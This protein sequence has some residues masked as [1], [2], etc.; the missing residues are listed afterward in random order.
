MNFDLI[1]F[2]A[3]NNLAG[4]NI[5]LDY[6]GIFL[7][8]YLGYVLIVVFLIYIILALR[9]KS[10]VKTSALKLVLFASISSVF[11]IVFI[12]PIIVIFISRPRPFIAL[13]N[14]HQLVTVPLSENLQSFPSG[15]ALIYFALSMVVYFSN[16]KLGLAFFIASGLMGLARIYSGVHYPSDILAGAILG[17]G[18]AYLVKVFY[19]KEKSL[20]LRI[21]IKDLKK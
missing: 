6:F 7:A 8:D 11:A 3:L 9:D 10:L 2:F 21:N 5:W 15:H 14:I 1:I 18:S 12:K 16:K 20:A 17:I 13:N 4:K 19:L